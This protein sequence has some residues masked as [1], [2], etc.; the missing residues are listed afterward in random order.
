MSLK[1]D[2]DIKVTEVNFVFNGA[3]GADN[4]TAMVYQTTGSGNATPDD[5]SGTVDIGPVAPS[6]APRVVGLLINPFV[7]YNPLLHRN[8]YKVTQYPGEKATLLKDGWV[9]LNNISPS[10]TPTAG[11][12][13]YLGASGTWTNANLG[14]E[15]V[16]QFMSTFDEYGYCRLYIKIS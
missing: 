9:T 16:G 12:D 7:P 4:G 1:P 11:Q 15:K 14:Q 6:G 10:I 5:K 13:A 8:I 2:R 3:Y